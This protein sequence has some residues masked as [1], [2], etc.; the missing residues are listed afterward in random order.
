[1]AALDAGVLQGQNPAQ[2]QNDPNQRTVLQEAK[3][4]GGSSTLV[5]SV[6]VRDGIVKCLN[7]R[8]TLFVQQSPL[9][10]SDVVLV[11]PEAEKVWAYSKKHPN[12]LMTEAKLAELVPRAEKDRS[13]EDAA[14]KAVAT[15]AAPD[16]KP[17]ED[18]LS[19]KAKLTWWAKR[20]AAGWGVM[21]ALAVVFLFLK[22]HKAKA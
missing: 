19:S 5:I 8:D 11:G 20:V 12:E 1:M 6:L 7:R 21:I 9:R 13:A 16:K 15:P 4:R 18:P 3:L 22:S 10:P 2:T 17:E 14:A